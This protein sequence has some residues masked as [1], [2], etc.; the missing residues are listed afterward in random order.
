MTV[1]WTI[2]VFAL[3][4][5]IHE[6]GHFWA[7][8][9]SGVLVHEFALGFGPRLA[10]VRRGETEYSLRLLPLGGFVRMAGMQPDEEGLEDVP[11]ERRFLGRPLGDRVKIIA[12]GPL[13]NVALA[14]VLFALVFAVIGVPVARPVVGEVVPGYPAA[15]AG[16][17]PG[18]R[19]VAID[20]RPVES[21]DQVVAAIREAAGRPVQLTIQ[22]QGRELAVQVTPRSDPRRPGT[23]VVGIRPLVETVRTGVVEAVSRGAQATWQVAAG[24]VTALVHMLTGRGGFDVIGPVGIGQ[25]IGEAAQV[26]LSQVVLLAAI[27]SANLALV[28]L[29]PVPALDGGRLVFLVVEAVRGRPVDPEQENLIHFVGFALLMLLAIVITY[30][31]LLRLNAS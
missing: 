18:D 8:K 21:W 24:F 17:Q 28:N 4:I 13:M 6:L 7:A 20:G 27:L 23:G 9:R 22:R 19:I 2:A 10:F 11:P 14:I 1:I 15:E 16:L 29:L 26:G 3:L 25:Q 12:A 5:V 31:D 30:R